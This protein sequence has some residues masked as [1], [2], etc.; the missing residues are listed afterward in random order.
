MRGPR[1]VPRRCTRYRA[2]NRTHLELVAGVRSEPGQPVAARGR[3]A[4]RDVRPRLPRQRPVVLPAALPV[5]PTRGVLGTAGPFQQPESRAHRGRPRS[6][7]DRAGVRGAARPFQQQG[8]VRTVGDHNDFRR[9]RRGRCRRTGRSWRGRG[10]RGRRGRGCCG[11]RGCGCCG[12]RGRGIVEIGLLDAPRCE[13]V[14]EVGRRVGEAL[15]VRRRWPLH[16]RW[17]RGGRP[18]RRCRGGRRWRRG[19]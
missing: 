12:R 19:G 3:A 7:R 5:L 6:A 1:A 14:S 10:C 8:V 2:R 18:R 13:A 15:Y 9:R 16:R 11:R 4:A 17:R